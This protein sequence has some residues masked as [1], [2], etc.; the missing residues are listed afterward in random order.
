MEQYSILKDIASE[1]NK[2]II[3]PFLTTK[4]LNYFMDK[5]YIDCNKPK[6]KQILIDLYPEFFRGFKAR[7]PINFQCGNS[8]LKIFLGGKN[9]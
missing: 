1:Y 8:K 7:R 2:E 5:T 6:V 9:E 4:M 3:A